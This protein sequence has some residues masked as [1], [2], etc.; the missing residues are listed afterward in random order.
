M[1]TLHR[2]STT[3]LGAIAI[4]KELQ[5][6]GLLLEAASCKSVAARR[7]LREGLEKGHT[8]LGEAAKLNEKAGGF[9]DA[10]F[11]YLELEDTR[12]LKRVAPKAIAQIGIGIETPFGVAL[13]KL[14]K[15]EDGS[16]EER[17]AMH[18]LTMAMMA[19]IGAE[20]ALA[21]ELS[22]IIRREQNPI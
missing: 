2:Y 1:Q 9:L 19:R 6:D 10:A 21:K 5:A 3:T 18:E 22:E 17:D 16:E 15:A 11:L 12:E 13:S 20:G 8:L 7:L 14:A 4:D